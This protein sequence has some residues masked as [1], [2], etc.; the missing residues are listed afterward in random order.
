MSSLP[1]DRLTPDKPPFPFVGVDY[2]GPFEVKQGR[3]RVNRYGCLFTC[4]TT[5]AV[6]IE[7][8]HSLD[9]DS[10]AN[11]LRRFISIRRCPGQIRSDRGTNFTRADKEPK[12][13]IEEWNQQKIDHVCGQKGIQWIF[14]PSAASDMGGVWERMIRSVSHILRAILIE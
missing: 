12:E 3:S 8:A 10:M 4:L 14:N 1:S 2:F 11:A 6:H 5:R 7:M 9:T 13:T